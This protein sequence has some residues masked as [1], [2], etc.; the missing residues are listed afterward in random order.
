VWSGGESRGGCPL[1][2]QKNKI[3]KNRR[4][5]KGRSGSSCHHKH[6]H[7]HYHSQCI[8]I[9]FLRFEKLINAMKMKCDENYNTMPR[10]F[11]KHKRRNV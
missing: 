5:G 11:S 3:K 10:K 8:L 2:I 9:L 4:G 6:F 1:L 7:E